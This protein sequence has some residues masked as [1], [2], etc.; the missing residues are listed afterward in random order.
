MGT[1]GVGTYAYLG[2]IDEMSF[3]MKLAKDKILLMFPIN[4]I[5][6]TILL[7]IEVRFFDEKVSVIALLVSFKF[8]SGIFIN[9]CLGNML[10]TKKYR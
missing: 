8:L 3:E 10:K 9:H 2:G 7:F 4:S 6:K 1:L 5:Y